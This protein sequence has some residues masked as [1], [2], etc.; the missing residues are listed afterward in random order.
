MLS[1][2]VT[3]L[4]ALQCHKVSKALV[5]KFEGKGEGVV[6]PLS[7]SKPNMIYD[8]PPGVSTPGSLSHPYLSRLVSLSSFMCIQP[9][10]TSTVHRRRGGGGGG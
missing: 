6:L 8:P 3:D 5:L 9:S 10:S 1:G 4:A 2:W 7:T